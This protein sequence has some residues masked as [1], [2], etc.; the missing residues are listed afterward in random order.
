[1][2]TDHY[3]ATYFCVR[4][5]KYLLCIRLFYDAE[6]AAEAMHSRMRYTRIIAKNDKTSK[7]QLPILL[8]H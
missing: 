8:R 2:N 6:T 3:F 1:M 4:R 7:N 5:W